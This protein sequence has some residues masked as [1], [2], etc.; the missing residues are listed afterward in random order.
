MS[1]IVEGGAYVRNYR[2]IGRT[3]KPP[4]WLARHE[5]H[6]GNFKKAYLAKIRVLEAD[7]GSIRHPDVFGRHLRV[8]RVH[9]WFRGYF[10]SSLSDAELM[11]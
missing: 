3:I 9:P 2:G 10:F 8:I 4:A 6:A 11:Q 1:R 7:V 5:V